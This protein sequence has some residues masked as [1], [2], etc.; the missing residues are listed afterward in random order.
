MSKRTCHD[1]R[2]SSSNNRADVVIWC[3][4]LPMSLPQLL[5]YGMERPGP[6]RISANAGE[7]CLAF[8]AREGKRKCW[9]WH[10]H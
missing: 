6:A 10:Q 4:W 1:C 9:L 7:A 3:K 2:F 8:D 5:P